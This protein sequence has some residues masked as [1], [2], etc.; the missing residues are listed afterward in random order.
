MEF[1]ELKRYDGN[2]QECGCHNA[3]CS[4]ERREKCI[5]E[6]YEKDEYP[7]LTGDKCREVEKS[8]M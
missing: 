2:C 7:C 8:W 3:S 1:C 4:D 5:E 6:C